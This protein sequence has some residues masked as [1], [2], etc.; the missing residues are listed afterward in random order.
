[1][2]EIVEPD[3]KHLPGTLHRRVE[4]ADLK[5]LIGGG[6]SG[7][8][9]VKK[10]RPG[11]VEVIDAVAKRAVGGIVDIDIPVGLEDDRTPEARGDAHVNSFVLSVVTAGRGRRSS[12]P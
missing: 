12:A 6:G 2:V 5:G 4:F 8:G 3:R 7:T 1:M 11:F 9:P 10:A